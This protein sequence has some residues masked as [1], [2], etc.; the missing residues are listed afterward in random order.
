MV[1]LLYMKYIRTA[2]SFL[3]NAQVYLVAL[4]LVILQSN[5][6]NFISGYV[7]SFILSTLAVCLLLLLFRSNL[8]L[9]ELFLPLVLFIGSGYL[10]AQYFYLSGRTE[11]YVFGVY[12][13]GFTILETGKFLYKNNGFSDK[14]HLFPHTSHFIASILALGMW[15]FGVDFLMMTEDVLIKVLVLIYVLVGS[16]IVFLQTCAQ[17]GVIRQQILKKFILCLY[18][19][20]G[21]TTLISL[22]AS[23]AFS[24]EP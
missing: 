17:Q 15:F 19:I 4:G 24:L 21:I 20:V 9:V 8:R 14:F 5:N 18:I 7:A 1:H 11:M 12:A 16:A 22:F 2:Y 13:F 10:L 3:W 23:F 6:S